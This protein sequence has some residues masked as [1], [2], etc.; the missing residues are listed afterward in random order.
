MCGHGA[1][2]DTVDMW[3]WWI[4][5]NT[6]GYGGYVDMVETYEYM[7]MCSLAPPRQSKKVSLDS[8]KWLP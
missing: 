7:W 2:D 6:C 4:H 3:T 8:I 5:M 1:Y